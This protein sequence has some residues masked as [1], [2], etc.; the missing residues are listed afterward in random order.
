VGATTTQRNSAGKKRQV[1]VPADQVTV[2]DRPELRIVEQAVWDRA[3]ARL[4]EL[5]ERYGVKEGQ[6]ARGPR[7]NPAELSPRSPLGGLLTCA[8]CGSG[9]WQ[10]RSN[11]RR[12][13]RCPGSAKGCCEMT[14]Q[15]PADRA[16]EALSDFLLGRL[17]S[18]PEWMDGL[19]RSVRAEIERAL[20]RVPEDRRR[21]ES[22]ARELTREIDNLV[23]TLASGGLVSAAVSR[24]LAELEGR[25]AEVEAR[26]SESVGLDSAT[27]ALPDP[28]WVAAQLGAWVVE[29][30]G[31]EGPQS[32]LRVGIESVQA[33]A[34]VAPGKKRGFARLRFRVNCWEVLG[35]THGDALPSPARSL[36]DWGEDSSG[37]G[38]E[39]TIDLGE[40]TPMDHW[41][42][43]IAAWREEGVKWEEIV[44]RTDMD[45]NRVCRA[46]ERWKGAA[47]TPG[48]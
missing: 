47:G 18:W 20:A 33:E 40:P 19:Y 26:L 48:D 1:V 8:R 12:Y 7:P 4:A 11:G 2:R 46:Y 42:P 39:F 6:K 29:A 35:A 24:R 27:I 44:R 17:A 43:Q 10:H 21:D 38:P 36:L 13:Y 41:A 23:N 34:V 16:E 37:D 25:R 30:A 22:L 45:L 5:D 31:K 28:A 14:T 9:M 15:V 32:L 3:A